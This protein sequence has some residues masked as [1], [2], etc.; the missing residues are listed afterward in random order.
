MARWIFASAS[1]ADKHGVALLGDEAAASEI[2]GEILIDRRAIELK[3]GDV[4]G[5][6]ELGNGELVFD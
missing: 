4:L 6:R 5:E 1:A 3:D 2:I